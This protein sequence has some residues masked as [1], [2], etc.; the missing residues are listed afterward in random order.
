MAEGLSHSALTTDNEQSKGSQSAAFISKRKVSKVN[1]MFVRRSNRLRSL[2]L[3]GKR[4]GREAVQHID[5]TECDRDKEQ[6]VEPIRGV[7]SSEI[8]VDYPVH[9]VRMSLLFDFYLLYVAKPD[10]FL[11]GSFSKPSQSFF[12]Y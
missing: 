8:E 12:S 9:T 5:L 2:G 1:N 3:F 11:K 10:T 4:Q 6:H 7:S